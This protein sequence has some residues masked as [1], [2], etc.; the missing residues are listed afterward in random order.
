[1]NCSC[2]CLDHA[3]VV[4]LCVRHDRKPC[5]NGYTDQDAVW[6]VDLHG[7]HSRNHVLDGVHMGATWR[8]RCAVATIIVTTVINLAF[9]PNRNL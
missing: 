3:W 4:H 9:E 8:I 6:D 2:A 7:S 1:M 5:I